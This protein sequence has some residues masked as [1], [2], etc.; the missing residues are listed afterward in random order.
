MLARWSSPAEFGM[1]IAA[2]SIVTVL[3]TIIGLGLPQYATVLRASKPD[4]PSI[5]RMLDFT[6]MTSL[7]S[8]FACALIVA[9]LA[10]TDSVF[11]YFLPLAFALGFQRNSAIWDAI[12]V[13]DGQVK[14][15]SSNLVLRRAVTFVVFS[16]LQVMEF[17]TVLAYCLAILVAAIVYNVRMRS[18]SHFTPV[19]QTDVRIAPILRGAF[20]FW[21][22]AISGIMRQLDVVLTSL[23]LGPLASGYLAVPSRIASPIMLLPTSIATLI[24]PKVSK[25]NIQTAKYGIYAGI[26]VSVFIGIILG[27]ISFFLEVLF[28]VVLGPEYLAAVYVTRIYFIGFFGLS[29]IY[30]FGAVIQGLGF[31]RIVGRNSV[32][33]SM[34]SL[35]LL[36][37]GAWSGGLE[38][39][40]WGYV[41]GTLA[42]AFT[43]VVI[44]GVVSHKSDL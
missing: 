1:T 26:I 2:Q 11:W 44:Y 40:A 17:Q 30:M 24:L 33:F 42:Q 7:L 35:T 37:V 36:C 14:L 23:I 5:S 27:V 12:V 19:R 38:L 10:W 21:V 18:N 13:A 4:S 15:F 29:I 16:V 22:D 34:V 31:Q 28:A 20:H 25:G 41:A 39:A 3:A 8:T 32:V 6:K 9:M 43:L